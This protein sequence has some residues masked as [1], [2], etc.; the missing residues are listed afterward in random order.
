MPVTG[1]WDTFQTVS[2]TLTGSASGPLFL[3][4]T[5]SGTGHLFD[6]DSFTLS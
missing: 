6:V 3:V 1:G 2:T 4:Y 5:G